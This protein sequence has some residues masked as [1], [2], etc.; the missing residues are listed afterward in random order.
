MQEK[1]NKRRSEYIKDDRQGGADEK[2]AWYT[3]GKI[4]G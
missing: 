3:W 2:Q 1:E 4:S